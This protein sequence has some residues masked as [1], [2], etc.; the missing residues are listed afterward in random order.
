MSFEKYF[1]DY[2][3]PDLFLESKMFED[4]SRKN[5]ACPSFA[6]VGSVLDDDHFLKVW[7]EHKDVDLREAMTC[8]FAITRCCSLFDE[9]TIFECNSVHDFLPF[10]IAHFAGEMSMLNRIFR[11]YQVSKT[12]ELFSL[13][14]PS[15]SYPACSA[16]HLFRFL[17][18]PNVF[19]LLTNDGYLECRKFTAG[20]DSEVD[21]RFRNQVLLDNLKHLQK[22]LSCEQ[23]SFSS[24]NCKG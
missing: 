7:V 18:M 12:N 9:K 24:C 17:N 22:C 8:R 23:V 20:E 2:Q 21:R 11:I 6:L 5:D 19:L 1:D 15:A 14:G 4:I 13:I 16:E 10:L 3:V